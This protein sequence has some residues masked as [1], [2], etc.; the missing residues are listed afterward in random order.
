[1][2]SLSVSAHGSGVR[3]VLQPVVCRVEEASRSVGGRGS[4]K[5]GTK[6]GCRGQ[7]DRGARAGGLSEKSKS[8]G[9]Q[10]FQGLHRAVR[11]IP[12]PAAQQGKV[13][14]VNRR[15]GKRLVGRMRVVQ[16][17]IE[18]EGDYIPQRN[19]SQVFQFRR[20]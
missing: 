8:I 9:S 11:K 1:M 20:F 2:Q 13:V 4:A 6:R 17:V 7:N 15:C 19:K 12:E 18:Q 3:T 10:T 16:R 14:E 5:A